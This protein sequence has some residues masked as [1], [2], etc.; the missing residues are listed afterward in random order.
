MYFYTSFQSAYSENMDI[1]SS[2][3]K[4]GFNNGTKYNR[5]IEVSCSGFVIFMFHLQ[6]RL[7]SLRQEFLKESLV[8]ARIDGIQRVVDD[9]VSEIYMRLAELEQHPEKQHHVEYVILVRQ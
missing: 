1:L 7:Y 4:E 5:F 8:Q 2:Y 6:T 3:Q 9:P